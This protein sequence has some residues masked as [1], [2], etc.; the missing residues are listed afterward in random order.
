MAMNLAS[1]GESRRK[2]FHSG[3]YDIPHFQ[4]INGRR[5][6]K[7]Y[8]NYYKNDLYGDLSMA[9]V[10]CFQVRPATKE[11]FWYFAR[12]YH[13][14]FMNRLESSA[15]FKDESKEDS[16]LYLLNDADRA[17]HPSYFAM[18]N[19]GDLDDG[20]FSGTGEFVQVSHIKRAISIKKIMSVHNF[21]TFRGRLLYSIDFWP[22]FI[23]KSVVEKWLKYIIQTIEENVK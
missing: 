20:L 11:Q 19:I 3:N 18:N 23:P 16:E 22:P 15:C 1:I 10:T 21:C 2:D 4:M 13:Y 8:K 17:Y 14:N 6:L 12:G 5:Y 7:K 9:I